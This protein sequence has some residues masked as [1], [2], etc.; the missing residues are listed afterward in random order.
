MTNTNPREENFFSK[1]NL[2]GEGAGEKLRETF[3]DCLTDEISQLQVLQDQLVDSDFAIGAPEDHPIAA[4]LFLRR[5][6]EG[7]SEALVIGMKGEE[8]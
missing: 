4:R 8:K 3:K 5:M 7:L 2:L 1:F 6:L